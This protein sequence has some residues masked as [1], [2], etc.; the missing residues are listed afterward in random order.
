LEVMT[1]EGGSIVITSNGATIKVDAGG[2][3]I[4]GA[5]I[6]LNS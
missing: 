3:T 6:N 1:I 5:K 4:N 2:V